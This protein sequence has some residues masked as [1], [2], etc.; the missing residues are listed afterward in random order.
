MVPKVNGMQCMY[1]AGNAE[2]CTW[3]VDGN[4]PAMEGAA[5][6][7]AIVRGLAVAAKKRISLRG[8]LRGKYLKVFPP[9]AISTLEQLAAHQDDGATF[10]FDETT[11]ISIILSAIGSGRIT[12][13]EVNIKVAELFKDNS[14]NS[15]VVAHLNMLLKFVKTQRRKLRSRRVSAPARSPSCSAGS[16][17]G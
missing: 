8:M 11:D 14:S 9:A 12:K 4:C 2:G 16:Q 5:V 17:V 1:C 6:N 15:T 13:S 7:A 10:T 3:G